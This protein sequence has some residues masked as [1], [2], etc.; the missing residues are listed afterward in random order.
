VAFF[1]VTIK[2]VELPETI[3][4]GF[5]MILTV[6]AGFEIAVTVTVALAELLPPLP[7]AVAV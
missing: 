5:A 7:V 4:D 1:A 6:G 2:V 3:E